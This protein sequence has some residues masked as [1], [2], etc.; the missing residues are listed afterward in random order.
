M[1]CCNIEKPV[2]LHEVCEAVENVIKNAQVYKKCGLKPNHLL[3]NLDSGS[4]R[5]TLVEYI[6]NMFKATNVLGFKSGIDDYIEFEFDGTL[7]QMRTVFS[8]I[9][10]AAV[11]ANEFKDLIAIGISEVANHLN[12]VQYT[13][14]IAKMKSVCEQA[15][16]IFFVHS[17]PSKNEE[18][19]IEKITN[20]IKNVEKVYVSKYTSEELACITEKAINEHGVDIEDYD[21]FHNLLT[22]VVELYKVSCVNDAVVLANTLIKLADFSSFIPHITN[23]ELETIIVERKE[24]GQV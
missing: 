10:S 7:Q 6:K 4:G 11:Y 23:K 2:G 3:V 19:L 16:V 18:R 24:R 13:E 8:E 1:K 15:L 17:T 12:E 22:D 14:F 5:T 21:E 20:N 9:D